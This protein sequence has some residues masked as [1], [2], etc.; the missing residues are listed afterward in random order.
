MP[1]CMFKGTDWNFK[2]N[3]IIYS[4][5]TRPI[6][7]S[8]RLRC[9]TSPRHVHFRGPCRVASPRE[10]GWRAYN[11]EVSF[12]FEC[13]KHAADRKDPQLHACHP[14]ACMGKVKLWGTSSSFTLPSHAAGWQACNWRGPCLPKWGEAKL[15]WRVASPHLTQAVGWWAN[16]WAASCS[17]ARL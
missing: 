11:W 8:I 1:K 3:C 5:G 17:I 4:A 14:A 9:S 15:W 7:P 6:L 2:A 16:N 12:L 13:S 10:T